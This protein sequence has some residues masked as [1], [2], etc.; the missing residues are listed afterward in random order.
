MT[1]ILDYQ[2]INCARKKGHKY[3]STCALDSRDWITRS[4]VS[5]EVSH[6][7]SRATVWSKLTN[8]CC[9]RGFRRF[10]RCWRYKWF[11]LIQ[12]ILSPK[13]WCF[14]HQMRHLRLPLERV[15]ELLLEHPEVLRRKAWQRKRQEHAI[16]LPRRIRLVCRRHPM[17]H[18]GRSHQDEHR[19]RYPMGILG[20]NPS[21][22][23]Q[24]PRLPPRT[25]YRIERRYYLQHHIFK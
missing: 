15:L 13:I 11:W 5:H 9:R 4:A 12:F 22:R 19:Y 10:I 6:E 23:S 25:S 17:R 1:N 2:K 21:L 16:C 8:W 3:R 24:E 7:I 18:W 20:W 14:P